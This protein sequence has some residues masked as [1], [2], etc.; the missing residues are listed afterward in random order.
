MALLREDCELRGLFHGVIAP[1]T[2]G[3]RERQI[4]LEAPLDQRKTLDL[5]PH[6]GVARTVP[7]ELAKRLLG[8]S[9]KRTREIPKLH[10]EQ[11]RRDRL[12]RLH[13]DGEDERV[14]RP[15]VLAR[16]AIESLEPN[17]GDTRLAA[18]LLTQPGCS[19]RRIFLAG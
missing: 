2:G 18:P 4:E 9:K 10:G 14:T 5:E 11:R 7:A 13:T 15:E 6:L 17:V 3:V 19:L 8:S 16:L 1:A 12:P